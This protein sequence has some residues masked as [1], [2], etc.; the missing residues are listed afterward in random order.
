MS[1]TA[2]YFE[3]LHIPLLKGRTFDVRDDRNCEARGDRESGIRSRIFS[4]RRSDRE[5]DSAGFRGVWRD[6]RRGIEIVGV[7]A[8]IRSTDLTD[9]PK[10]GFYLPYDQA[11][12]FAARRDSCAFREIRWRI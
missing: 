2:N 5:I 6:V 4:K 12:L 9:T 3:T 7:V 10:P 8:G 1:I 11:T